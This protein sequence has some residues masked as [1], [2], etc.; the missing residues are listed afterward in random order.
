[1]SETIGGIIALLLVTSLSLLITRI[2]TCILTFTGLSYDS[3]RF[4]ARS[5]LVGCGFTTRE[6][7]SVVEHPVRRRVIMF[8][9]LLGNGTILLMVS[10]LIPIMTGEDNFTQPGWWGRIIWL[11]V[12]LIILWAIAVSKLF[13]RLLFRVTS[14]ALRSFTTLDVRDY[15][16][17]LHLADGYTVTEL[18]VEASDWLVG[19]SLIQARLG[20]EGIHVL[21]IR[22]K[23]G[24]YIGAP[25]GHTY[26]RSGDELI[27]YGKVDHLAE[28]DQRP[29]GPEGD[30]AHQ[31]RCEEQLKVCEEQ[32]RQDGSPDVDASSRAGE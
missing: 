30:V 31:R 24:N 15:H 23:E 3:A 28:L 8:L 10:S 17:L 19:K 11:V 25:T 29:A 6:A 14:W 9:M 12:G 22:R 5:A 4:Q 26:V 1:M 18:A 16:G 7:E 20:D 32:R 27:L 21:G 2:A 13:D